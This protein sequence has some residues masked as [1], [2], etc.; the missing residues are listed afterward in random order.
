MGL[1]IPPR[2]SNCCAL[3]WG[4]YTVRCT[5]YLPTPHTSASFSRL[6]KGFTPHQGI[7]PTFHHLDV[8]PALPVYNAFN[9]R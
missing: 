5:N 7:T 2:R 1:R 9:V 4:S 3:P 8:P 6:L